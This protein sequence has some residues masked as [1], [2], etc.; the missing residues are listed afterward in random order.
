MLRSLYMAPV[1][2]EIEGQVNLFSW[3]SQHTQQP[4]TKSFYKYYV[5][6][7]RTAEEFLKLWW[8]LEWEA[9]YLKLLWNE[10]NLIRIKILNLKGEVVLWR[11]RSTPLG[12]ENIMLAGSTVEGQ[13][14]E[15][16]CYR[17]TDVRIASNSFSTSKMFYKCIDRERQES[18][19]VLE[20]NNGYVHEQQGNKLMTQSKA[21]INK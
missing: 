15:W 3:N 14:D 6:D 2:K 5:R 21:K 9:V 12:R 13:P 7:V 16:L 4:I 19:E 17:I 20:Y 1:A 18:V 10:V 8:N 11:G